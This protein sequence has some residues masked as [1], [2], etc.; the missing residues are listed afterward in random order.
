MTTPRKE[1]IYQKALELFH[2]DD[3]KRG[4]RSSINPTQE[5]LAED[6]YISLAMSQLMRCQGHEYSAYLEEERAACK[7]CLDHN[8]SEEGL[9]IDIEECKRSN[10][11]VSGTNQMG[12]SLCAMSIADRLVSEGWQVICFDTCGNWKRKSSIQQVAVIKSMNDKFVLNDGKSVIFDIAL[13]KLRNQKKYIES[14]LEDLWFYRVVT[15]PKQ[16]CMLIFEEFQLSAGNL[17]GELS[18][19]LLRIMSVGANYRVRSLGITPDLSLIDTAF[20]RL[21]QQRY[22]FKLGNEPNAKRR[23]RAY[24]GLDWCRIAKE[25]DV[26]YCIYV[27][28][29]KIGV[30]KVPLFQPKSQFLT[31]ETFK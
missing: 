21:A 26:G 11:L 24:Y 1:E 5:E 4:T 23:F 6:G 3:W 25:L 15:L 19:N 29:E 17:R 7:T 28:K 12:K 2:N 31:T 18:Q 22:H 8:I 9:P 30:W 10:L 20:I 27:N 16:W 14:F 13:L